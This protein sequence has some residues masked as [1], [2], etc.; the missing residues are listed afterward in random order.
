MKFTL[1]IALLIALSGCTSA[2]AV[3]RWFNVPVGHYNPLIRRF[4]DLRYFANNEFYVPGG[5]IYIYIGGGVEVY[6]DFLNQGAVYEIARDTGGYLFALEHRYFGESRP[7]DDASVSNLAFL[8]IHQA[9][10]DIG[11]FIEFIKTNYNGAR[12]SPVIL[13]G[14]GKL[15]SQVILDL[16]IPDF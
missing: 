7:T 14:K 12:N 5:P 6:D 16:I 8:T 10:A 9:V 1:L 15:G 11:E 4:F 2:Q 3:L 13:W